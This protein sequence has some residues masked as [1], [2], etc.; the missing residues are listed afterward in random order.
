MAVVAGRS[1][2]SLE[3]MRSRVLASVVLVLG[4]IAQ[5]GA[6]DSKLPE[7]ARETEA[8]LLQR[9]PVGTVVAAAQREMESLGFSCA[10]N[11]DPSF[12]PK[13]TVVG[14]YLYCDLTTRAIVAQRWQVA[15]AHSQG[16]VTAIHAT[17]GLIGP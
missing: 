17:Y 1:T 10:P 15:L 5:A 16:K 14:T 9:I 12:G 11:T 3:R 13:G 8:V 7:S 2:R 6:S 4:A